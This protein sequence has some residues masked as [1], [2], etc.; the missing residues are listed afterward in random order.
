MTENQRTEDE[1][2]DLTSP[3]EETHEATA[4]PGGGDKDEEA[5]ESGEDRLDQAGH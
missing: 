4:P 5:I 1:G 3:P 2:R